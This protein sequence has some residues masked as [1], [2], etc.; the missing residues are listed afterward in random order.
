V[1]GDV[2]PSQY[3]ATKLHGLPSYFSSGSKIIY[4]IGAD[5]DVTNTNDA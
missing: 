2:I 1:N 3:T 5:N 4:N